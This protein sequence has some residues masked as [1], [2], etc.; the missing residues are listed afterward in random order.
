[1][2]DDRPVGVV[3]SSSLKLLT[4]GVALIAAYF[5]LAAFTTI[6]DE[7]DIGGG[8][9]LGIGYLATAGGVFLVSKDLLS[10]RSKRK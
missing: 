8:L 6:G 4:L 5:V 1:M 7:G 2:S 10:H 3:R 9:I